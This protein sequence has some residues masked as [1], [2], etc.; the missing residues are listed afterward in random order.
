M[1]AWWSELSG[2]TQFFYGMAVFFSV[3]FL[4]QIVAAFMGLD[5]DDVDVSGA[6][7]M[8]MDADIDFDVDAPDDV[9][10][11]DVVESSQAFK[12]LSL[13][14]IITFFTLF[15]WMAAL[16]TTQGVELSNALLWSSIWGV[17]GMLIVAFIFYGMNR[18]TETGTKDMATARGKTGTVYL[19][20]PAAGFGE[21][22]VEVNGAIEHIKAKSVDGSE[23]LAGTEVK[24]VQVMSQTLVGVV[25][26]SG[27]GA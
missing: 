19:N 5:G 4:W 27:E 1:N 8:D 25:K 2:I 24:I 6:G 16:Y 22:K 7:D 21:V 9:S 14:S 13:R 23:L 20:I 18:L 3:F 17:V 26:L 12:V 11:A 15:S 10:H